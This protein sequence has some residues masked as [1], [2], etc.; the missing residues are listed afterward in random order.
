MFLLLFLFVWFYG[1]PAQPMSCGAETGMMIV[2]YLGCFKLKEPIWSLL[3]I[4]QGETVP[5]ILLP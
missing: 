2:A 4:T 5:V 1:A 3:T